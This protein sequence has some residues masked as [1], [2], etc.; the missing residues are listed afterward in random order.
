MKPLRATLVAFVLAG[1]TA[2]A[3]PALAD[4]LVVRSGVAPGDHGGSG[5]SR[6]HHGMFGPGIGRGHHGFGKFGHH[7]RFRHHRTFW[8]GAFLGYGG[9]FFFSRDSDFFA[10]WSGPR[11]EPAYGRVAY[12]YDRGYP[13]DHYD[14]GDRGGERYA[15]P[16]RCDTEWAW[17]ARERRDV[18]IRVCRR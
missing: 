8:P 3:A 11:T 10:P 14:D 9:D 15:P 2:G 1:S 13:Y 16:P 17:D 7:G 5:F 18:P 12:D 4:S 6:N